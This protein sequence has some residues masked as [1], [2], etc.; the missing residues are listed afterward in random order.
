M[1]DVEAEN[2][3]LR[4]EKLLLTEMGEQGKKLGSAIDRFDYPLATKILLDYK[5]QINL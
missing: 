3:Y 5:K 2:L 1:H 4:Y